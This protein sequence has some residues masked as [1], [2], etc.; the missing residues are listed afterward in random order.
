MPV[1]NSAA[2][3]QRGLVLLAA[4]LLWAVPS[5]SAAQGGTPG[6]SPLLERFE[7]GYR[8]VL[9]D[10]GS[11]ILPVSAGAAASDLWKG[12]HHEL[13]ELDGVLQQL[14]F[15]LRQAPAQE[16]EALAER[17]IEGGAAR[18][19]LLMEYLQRLERLAAADSGGGKAGRAAPRAI[20][21]APEEP[22]PGLHLE[23]KPEDLSRG[24]FE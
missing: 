22:P 8:Q 5:G 3:R 18:A 6:A 24:K 16:R 2:P 15:Q 11:G 12:L 17:L 7:S 9:R 23:F 13:A 21:E 19:R 1:K 14:K 10:A 4:L 20:Q